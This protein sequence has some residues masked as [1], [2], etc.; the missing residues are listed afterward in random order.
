MQEGARNENWLPG[1]DSNHDKHKQ[2][3]FCNLQ[4]LQW[5]KMPDWARK[6]TTRTQLV[7]DRIQPAAPS[8]A[9][10]RAASAGCGD[11][12]TRR[13]H[14]GS[15]VLLGEMFLVQRGNKRGTPLLSAGTEYVVVR[16]WG[17]VVLATNGH[18]LCLLPQQ[19]D[20]LA[21]E[22]SSNAEPAED[23]L[24]FRENF[25]G[26]QPGKRPH[27]YPLTKKRSARVLHHPPGFES[28]YSGDK[29][30]RVDYTSRLFSTAQS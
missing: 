11:R 12:V 25:F 15:Q 2:L 27:L 28:G 14:L 17:K 4:S 30:R 3:R 8:L 21:H 18:E 24:V 16:I 5:S 7:H 10:G 6:T 9:P 13:N 23:S 26:N 20:D 1:M 22:I 29:Y 19:V